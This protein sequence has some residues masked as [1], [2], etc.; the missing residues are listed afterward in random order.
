[1]KRQ[2]LPCSHWLLLLL[3]L[4]GT[5]VPPAST[6]HAQPPARFTDRAA[7]LGIHHVW[8][9]EATNG[10]IG[11]GMAMEDYDED[12]DQDLFLATRGSETLRIYRNDGT[13]F[14]DVSTTIGVDLPRDQKQVL[15]AD[16]DDDGWRDLFVTGWRRIDDTFETSLHLFQ[17]QG[18]GTFVDVTA[19]TG[20]AT[21]STAPG[22]PLLLLAAGCAVADMDNDGDLDLYV[23]YWKGG[24]FGPSSANVLYRNDG[25][26]TF[27]DVT[28]QAGVGDPKKTYQPTAV[29]LSGDGWPDIVVPNDK[30][31]GVRYYENDGTGGFVDRSEASGLDGRSAVNGEPAD[32]MGTAVGDYDNDGLFDVLVTNIPNKGS[33]LYHNLG[34]GQF[35]EESGASEVRG[36]RFGWGACFADVDND[37]KLDLFVVNAGVIDTNYLFYN[38]TGRRFRDI[39]IGAGVHNSGFSYA[40][41]AGD[42]NG[43]GFVDLV[44]NHGLLQPTVVYINEG[45]PSHWLRL[46]LEGTVS[47]RDGIGAR[48]RCRVGDVWQT[49]TPMAGT[50]FLSHNPHTLY[51]GLGDSTRVDALEVTWPSGIV[52]TFTGVTSDREYHLT[53]GGELTVLYED[54]PPTPRRVPELTLPHPNPFNPDVSL[55]AMLPDGS[56]GRRVTVRVVDARG[57][58]VATLLDGP[59]TADTLDLQ[60]TAIDSDG[61]TVASGVYHVVLEIGDQTATASLTLIR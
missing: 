16:F 47:N 39:A 29:D 14:T 43:D 32:G 54:P 2:T 31:G 6:A 51:F 5:T 15:L 30:A 8:G 58:Q 48:A 25:G 41:V 59:A 13:S 24:V 55:T 34:D 50:S 4:L 52:D 26:L 38:Q 56:T 1:M 21:R 33:L 12:G 61:R 45:G 7:A 10:D 17:N 44:V 37:G 27:T 3:L 40:A 35:E 57:R 36:D 49:R 22:D 42:L 19:G 23:G 28:T 60:W 18:D 46:Q 20:L 9:D 11:A 53:E